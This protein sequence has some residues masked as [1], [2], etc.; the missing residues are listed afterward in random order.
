MNEFPSTVYFV[1]FYVMEI[2]SIH[3]HFVCTPFSQTL[4]LDFEP[5]RTRQTNRECSSPPLAGTITLIKRHFVLNQ[6]CG[7]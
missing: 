7:I 4:I 2:Y 5:L 3:L 1:K 6:Q